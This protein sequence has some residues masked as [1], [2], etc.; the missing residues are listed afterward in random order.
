[1]AVEALV[2]RVMATKARVSLK[3]EAKAK[4]KRKAKVEDAKALTGRT[5][6]ETR[7]GSGETPALRQGGPI[8]SPLEGSKT[9]GL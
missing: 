2:A 8:L 4:V 3:D 9:R 1:M 7:T 6:T 5:R